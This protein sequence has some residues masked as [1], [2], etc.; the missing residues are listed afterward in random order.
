MEHAP[1]NAIVVGLS[2]R[3]PRCGQGKL[4]A[5]Y[6][7][8]AP[9]CEVCDLDLGFADSADGPAVFLMFIVGFVVVGG[10]LWLE[11]SSEPPFWVHLLIWPTLTAALSLALLR[12]LKGLM[13]ALQYANRAREGRLER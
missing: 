2:G 11:F 1:Q 10:A 5:G 12:P 13:I 3:C 7:R 4:F 6:L 9:R 8:V